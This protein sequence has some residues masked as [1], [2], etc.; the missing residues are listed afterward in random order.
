MF[1]KSSKSPFILLIVASRLLNFCFKSL[2]CCLYLVGVLVRL[3][4]TGKLVSERI[5]FEGVISTGELVALGSLFSVHDQTHD[6]TL[7]SSSLDDSKAR[8]VVDVKNKFLDIDA[9]VGVVLITT[10]D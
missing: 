6:L 7:L 5:F 4:D 3:G 8:F 2:I 1:F 10:S 9:F